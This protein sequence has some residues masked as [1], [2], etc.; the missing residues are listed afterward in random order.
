MLEVSQS[1]Q[2]PVDEVNLMRDSIQGLINTG[3]L[4]P[5]DEIVST[6]H[7]KFVSLLSLFRTRV[8]LEWIFTDA[9][10]DC[11]AMD[12]LLLRSPGMV[13]SRSCSPSSRTSSPSGPEDVSV[14]TSTKVRV[15]SLSHSLVVVKGILKLIL[16]NC[17]L[18][19][20]NQDHS[21]M[22]GV[23][24]ADNILFGGLEMTLDSPDFVNGRKNEERR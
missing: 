2:K 3:L 19:V 8:H 14:H 9:M 15:S 1:T 5:E 7:R 4:Q 17:S 11:R 22:V 24:A 10:I 23:D 13:S 6:Y 20:A 18:I 12:T 21:F 16:L